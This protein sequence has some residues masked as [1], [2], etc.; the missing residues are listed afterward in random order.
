MTINAP[1][2]QMADLPTR[3][4]GSPNSS[5]R[6]PNSGCPPRS[7]SP[8]THTLS[9]ASRSTCTGTATRPWGPGCAASARSSR[10]MVKSSGAGYN[11]FRQRNWRSRD[12]NSPKVSNERHGHGVALRVDGER[13]DDLGHRLGRRRRRLDIANIVRGRALEAEDVTDLAGECRGGRGRVRLP[14]R[15]RAAVIRNVNIV[16]RDSRPAGVVLARSCDGEAGRCLRD[17]KRADNRA[18]I[19]PCP[20]ETSM[21]RVRLEAPRAD[22]LV[23][24]SDRRICGCLDSRIAL[25]CRRRI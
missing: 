5:S 11:S 19:H 25:R 15:E 7:M 16:A 10:R 8:G 3:A 21:L 17:R 23:D 24:C 20:C 14:E 1:V 22:A 12:G 13:Q 6:R 4:T 18:F 9:D 2:S